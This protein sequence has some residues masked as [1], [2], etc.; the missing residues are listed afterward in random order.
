MKL[1]NGVYARY[2]EKWH[3][4]LR[5]VLS[6]VVLFLSETTKS[7]RVLR[8]GTSRKGVLEGVNWQ[9]CGEK[10]S[11]LALSVQLLRAISL[12]MSFSLPFCPTPNDWIRIT[13]AKGLCYLSSF[14]FFV[15]FFFLTPFELQRRAEDLWLFD[16][17]S[18]LHSFFSEGGFENQEKIP[19]QP[20]PLFC[21]GRRKV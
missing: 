20:F 17:M 21:K 2:K 16:R 5:L 3:K 18:V 6:P 4:I 19:I 9:I 11:P 8:C 1:C 13:A 12:A 7:W 15:V 10:P 14:S